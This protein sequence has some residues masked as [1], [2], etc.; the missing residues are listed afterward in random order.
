MEKKNTKLQRFGL[1]AALLTFAMTLVVFIGQLVMPVDAYAVTGCNV[2]A[3]C[4]QILGGCFGESWNQCVEY[5]CNGDPDCGYAA[6]VQ[7]WCQEYY[8]QEQCQTHGAICGFSVPDPS[9]P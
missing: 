3:G 5:Y 2:G 9:C 8:C 7:C 1:T 4:A 6:S